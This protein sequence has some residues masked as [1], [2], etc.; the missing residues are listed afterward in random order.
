MVI[1]RL[2]LLALACVPVFV[3]FALPFYLRGS[4]ALLAA[5]GLLLLGAALIWL[6]ETRTLKW[7]AASGWFNR[8]LETS[9]DE[10]G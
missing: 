3:A 6:V 9:E 8:L 7:L 2:L 4:G 1:I 5:A 10:N